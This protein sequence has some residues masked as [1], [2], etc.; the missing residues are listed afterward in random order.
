MTILRWMDTTS[1][2][3]SLCYYRLPKGVSG[4]IER[5]RKSG[6]FTQVGIVHA[7]RDCS[8]K[9]G[10]LTQVGIAQ[11]NMNKASS[12]NLTKENLFKRFE[13]AYKMGL[14]NPEVF[15]LMERQIDAVMRLEGGQ[16]HYWVDFLEAEKR[17]TEN[18]AGHKVLA[19]DV[20]GYKAIQL[21]AILT[22][23][24]QKCAEDP[25]AWHTRAAFCEHKD[26]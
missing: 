2:I 9:S 26:K 14:L 15:N 18:F 6:L 11:N 1:G 4:S 16:F 3:F 23:Q 22:H 12:E 25:K 5:V 8:R 13:T 10:L 7:S 17:R 21:M 20:M 19:G 24:C